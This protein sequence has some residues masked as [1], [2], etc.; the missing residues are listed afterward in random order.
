MWNTIDVQSRGIQRES[1][2]NV[3]FLRNG[4]YNMRILKDPIFFSENVTND[5][6][7]YV[8]QLLDYV[9]GYMLH[10]TVRLLL[11]VQK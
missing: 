1:S 10:H 5:V 7:V 11:S 9:T 4:E 2:G 3:K 6:T 8:L